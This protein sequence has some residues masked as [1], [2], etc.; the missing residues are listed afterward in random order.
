MSQTPPITAELLLNAYATGYFPM[1]ENETATELYWFNPDMRG[2]LTPLEHFHIPNSLKK[3]LRRSTATVTIDTAFETVITACA[4]ARTGTR[5]SSWI[6]AQIIQLY[7]ELHE[8]GHAHSVEVWEE[9]ALIG[10]LY[11]VSL[12]GAF[13]GE[14]M[15]SRQSNASKIALVHLVARLK[16]AGYQLLDAQFE[17]PHL[18]QFGFLPIS[19]ED[20]LVALRKALSVSPNPSSRFA[21]VSVVPKSLI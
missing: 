7:C 19:K 21:T 10:G 12:G 18:T 6:N 15:F 2:V 4:N 20:Y 14:S 11:G 13:F 8:K 5:T 16:A 3:A 17:N 9:D 1:A